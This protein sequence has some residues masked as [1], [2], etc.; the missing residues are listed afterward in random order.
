M[1]Y[2]IILGFL[3]WKSFVKSELKKNVIFNLFCRISE[4]T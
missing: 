2:T 3:K 1:L 4:K